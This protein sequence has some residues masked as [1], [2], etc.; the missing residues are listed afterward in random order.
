MILISSSLF[1]F[2][3]KISHVHDA[4]SRGSLAE[5]QKLISEEPKK[6]LAIAKDPAGT[7]LL[8][9]AVYHDRRDIVEWLVQNFPIAVQ[10]KDRV[11]FYHTIF[12][13]IFRIIFFFRIFRQFSFYIDLS[14]FL[15][16]LKYLSKERK[17]RTSTL[18][19]ELFMKLSGTLTYSR[20]LNP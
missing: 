1:I 14:Q 12:F 2:Q 9:K 20:T 17:F 18:L 15:S 3:T 16:I 4:A 6:K 19:I 11:N 13:L 5:V 8:H 7:P 10:Q